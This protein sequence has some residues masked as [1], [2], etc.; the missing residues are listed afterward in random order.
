MKKAF[1]AGIVLVSGLLVA[2]MLIEFALWGAE[3]GTAVALL[4]IFA[5]ASSLF[6]LAREVFMLGYARALDDVR[7]LAQP[8]AVQEG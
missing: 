4:T 2:M 5:G 7:K 1:D 8:P 6:R 3:R